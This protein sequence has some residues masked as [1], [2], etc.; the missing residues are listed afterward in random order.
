MNKFYLLQF[1]ALLK[2]EILEH[3]NLFIGAPAV[4]GFLLF[5]AAVWAM[6]NLDAEAIAQLLEYAANLFE[7][8]SPTAMAPLFMVASVPFIMMLY[9]CCL[10][11]LANALYQDRK[12]QSVLFWQSMPVSNFKTV[13]SKVVTV[14]LVAPVFYV[15][16]LFVIYVIGMLWLTILGLTYVVDLV[17]LGSMFA[18]VLTSLIL[19][20]LSAFTTAMWLL[21]SVGWLLLFSAFARKTPLLWAL[22]VYILVGF[23]EDFIFSTQY[24]GNWVDSRSNPSQYIIFSF[25]N[26]IDRLFNYDMLFGIFVG[27]ILIGGAI[28]MRRFT[29]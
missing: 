14:A 19:V 8:L 15:G 12:E 1:Y 3:R 22:G 17:G 28:L 4:L 21:P 5:V 20:Y 18:A 7:G 24:L 25:E 9:V 26:V 10:I 29:D 6:S 13:L 11:Y 23:L 27:S 2:R 16:I